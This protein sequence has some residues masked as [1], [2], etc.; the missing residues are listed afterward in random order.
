MKEFST[1]GNNLRDDIIEKRICTETGYYIDWQYVDD[2]QT[3]IQFILKSKHGDILSISSSFTIDPSGIKVLKTVSLE[4]VRED[5]KDKHKLYFQFVNPLNNFYCDITEIYDLI[6]VEE[7]RATTAEEALQTSLDN[8]VTRAIKAETALSSELISEIARIDTN[9]ATLN[10]DLTTE[11][12]E[13]LDAFNRAMEAIVALTQETATVQ[14]DLNTEITRAKGSESTLQ[15]NIDTESEIRELTDNTLQATIMS[16][17]SRAKTAEETLQG[18]INTNIEAISN[19]NDYIDTVSSTIQV[20]NNYLETVSGNTIIRPY[21]N[22]QGKYQELVNNIYDSTKDSTYQKRINFNGIEGTVYIDTHLGNRSSIYTAVTGE[23]AYINTNIL[24]DNNYIFTQLNG[25]KATIDTILEGYARPKIYVKGDE[26]TKTLQYTYLSTYTD[27]EETCPL[28]FIQNNGEITSGFAYDTNS[29]GIGYVTKIEDQL[30][31]TPFNYLSKLETSG[32][33][34]YAHSGESQFELDY[35]LL[36]KA[37]TIAQRTASGNLLMTMP[38]ENLAGANKEYV[39]N[40]VEEKVQEEALARQTATSTLESKINIETT[41][42]QA[43]DSTILSK[44]EETQENLQSQID[45]ITSASDVVDVVATKDA[46]NNYD[47]SK[48]TDKDIIKVLKDESQS[49]TTTYYRF[50]KLTSSFNLI[51]GVGPYYTQSEVDSKVDTLNN[52]LTAETK[53][54]EDAITTI[55]SSLNNEVEARN[56]ADTTLQTAITEAS[57]ALTTEINK[58]QNTITESNKLDA[59]LVNGLASV[60]TTGSYID[61]SNKPTINA[62]TFTIQVSGITKGSYNASIQSADSTINIQASDLNLATVATSGSYNDLNNT[63]AIP[64]NVSELINDKG[65]TTNAGTVTSVTV[66]MN[67][68]AKGTVTTSGEIDLG[69]VATIDTNTTYSIDTVEGNTITLTGSDGT[70]T[71]KTINNVANAATATNLV[72]AGSFATGTESSNAIT[73][74]VGGKKSAEFTIPYATSA[75]TAISATKAAQD[76]DGNIITTTYAKTTAIPTNLSQLT[77]DSGYTKNTGTVTSV[78][79]KMNGETKGTITSSGE[80]NLGN[81]A[82]SDTN[83][84]YTLSADSLNNKIKLTPSSGSE[85]SITVPFATVAECA[86]YLT[87][88]ADVGGL[89]NPVYFDSDGKPQKCKFG[90]STFNGVINDTTTTYGTINKLS[91]T[92]TFFGLV[93]LYNSESNDVLLSGM[94]L[95]TNGRMAHGIGGL[96]G[97]Y[98]LNATSSATEEAI[99]IT[100]MYY[101]TTNCAIVKS[102]VVYG[103]GHTAYPS[104]LRPDSYRIIKLFSI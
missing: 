54:R 94:A 85:Q 64:T 90:S 96:Q 40:V 74:T 87:S 89:Y 38:T 61:L 20:S 95:F 2:E 81:I 35:D 80:I 17:G 29:K 13:R 101:D 18:Q 22:G 23:G 12:T 11:R 9:V 49:D 46:L 73:F 92:S 71:K 43:G 93:F 19:I 28:L 53:T 10:T 45:A 16:E 41:D 82:T 52:G 1:F 98:I 104:S 88:G 42:R 39:D 77:N 68:D 83:T 102:L 50:D 32:C 84:T 65:Y 100:N 70:E 79:V 67:G 24:G 59:G 91:D 5:S 30:T 75:G 34:L 3:S 66:K 26:T 6:S 31:F 44:I 21:L 86:D 60:A 36:A 14:N 62:G 56:T 58:K 57:T 76:S 99:I 48:L 103:D 15:F 8:E 55:V 63:P 4:K 7:S 37:N 33:K 78:S 97:S 25:N 69:T 47:K 27:T 72:S 51:G